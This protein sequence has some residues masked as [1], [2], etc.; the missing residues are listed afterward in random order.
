MTKKKKVTKKAKDKALTPKQALVKVLA[1]Q[2]EVASGAMGIQEACGKHDMKLYQYSYWAKKLKNEEGDALADAVKEAKWDVVHDSSPAAIRDRL[3]RIKELEG[4]VEMQ[5]SWKEQ[6][7]E[8]V[9]KLGES[10]REHQDR[11][12]DLVTENEQLREKLL[13]YVLKS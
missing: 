9:R 6:S 3:K 1:I 8:E 11:I 5:R 2:T 4:Q 7:Q 10:L 12:N 13:E